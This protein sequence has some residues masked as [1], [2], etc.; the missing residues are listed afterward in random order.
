MAVERSANL[1]GEAIEGRRSVRAEAELVER[2]GWTWI[3]DSGQRY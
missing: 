3:V 1:S 2:E